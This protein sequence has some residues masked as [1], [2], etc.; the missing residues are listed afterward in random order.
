M[1]YFIL[2]YFLFL[3]RKYREYPITHTISIIS[4]Y[5]DFYSS[6]FI[7]SE[8]ED[9]ILESVLPTMTSIFP[10][11]DFCE[12][13]IDIIRY[14]AKIEL[15]IELIEPYERCYTLTGEIHIGRRLQEEYFFSIVVSLAHNAM[16]FR[17]F[18]VREIPCFSEEVD[19]EKS[20]IMPSRSILFSRIS[21]TDD[22]FHRKS[23]FFHIRKSK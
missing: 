20:D 21:K 14:H 1:K 2:K 18:P 23:L 22:D 15:R 8:F 7:R 10:K 9:D 16:E 17:V 6:K 5:T 12:F 11:S 4:P 13:H 19:H 3:F